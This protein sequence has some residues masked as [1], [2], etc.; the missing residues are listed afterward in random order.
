MSRRRT[1]VCAC[2]PARESQRIA[3]RIRQRIGA[4]E[5]RT[6]SRML[7]ALLTPAVVM[8]TIRDMKLL[9]STA[10]ALSLL[11]GCASDPDAVD[12]AGATSD[13]INGVVDSGH[14]FVVL[15]TPIQG[16]FPVC[17][18]TLIGQAAVLTAGH[19]V[20]DQFG[21]VIPRMK[22]SV[23]QRECEP[24][25]GGG[26]VCNDVLYTYQGNTVRHP[27]FTPPAAENDVALIRLDT[28]VAGTGLSVRGSIATSPAA[29]TIKLVGYGV[30]FAATDPFAYSYGVLR[31][32]FNQIDS[33]DANFLYFT[34]TTG[35]DSATCFGDSGGPAFANTAGFCIAGITKGQ[36][37]TGPFCG[38][39]SGAFQHARVDIH[40]AWIATN[41]G[42]PV[43]PCA[44]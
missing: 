10:V 34:G 8:Y 2:G 37:G 41:A 42:E 24:G 21:A 15:V 20:T 4:S 40:A 36:L 6:R 25:G 44:P 38:D 14:R 3:L 19:C 16:Q 28:A 12:T 26:Q 27:N 17:T 35:T 30:P 33:V 32:G 29:G 5:C 11:A 39:A 31:S 9:V 7:I 1:N 18:G 22:I 13:I 23:R 43:A